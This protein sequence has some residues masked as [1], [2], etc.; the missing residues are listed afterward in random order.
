MAKGTFGMFAYKQAIDEN[1]KPYKNKTKKIGTV[2][3][4]HKL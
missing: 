2:R 4:K 3:G 1:L